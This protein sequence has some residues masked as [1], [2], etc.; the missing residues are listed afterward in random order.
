MDIKDLKSAWDTY[1]S[2]EMDKHRLEK[3][4][5]HGLLKSRTNSLVERIDR[6]IRIGILILL[7]YIVYMVADDLYFSKIMFIVPVEYPSWLVPI[8]V[9]SNAL[10][11]TTY[12]FFVVRYLRIKRSF[13]ADTQLKNRLSGILE[14]LKTYRRMFYLV[15]IILIINIIISFTAGIY[16]GVKFKTDAAN[17]EI[18]DLSFGKI[19]KIVAF[20]LAVLIPLISLT[21]FILHRGFKSLYGRYLV[22]LNETLQEL[23]ESEVVEN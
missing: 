6:N 13:S 7:G 9:F 11:V 22:K 12:L 15:V 3:E 16:H 18:I 5:I 4:N 20:G 1:S 10:I 21:F 23:D 2:Q 8:D 19:M 17:G 14:T